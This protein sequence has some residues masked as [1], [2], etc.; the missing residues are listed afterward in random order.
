MEE[1]KKLS[2]IDISDLY[3][4]V[5]DALPC[6]DVKNNYINYRPRI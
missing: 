1:V 4:M 6:W 2:D 3:M 5:K